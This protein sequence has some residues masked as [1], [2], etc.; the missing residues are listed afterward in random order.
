[1]VS[2]SS[3]TSWSYIGFHSPFLLV[4]LRPCQLLQRSADN[5]E[6]GTII[7]VAII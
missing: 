1:M 5:V 2:T 4:D 3:S 7:P 6:Q